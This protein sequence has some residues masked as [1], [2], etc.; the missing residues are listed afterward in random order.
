[1]TTPPTLT[2]EIDVL[3]AA[4]AAEY[5]VEAEIGR[6]G[7]AVVFRAV[8]RDLGRTVALKVLPLAAASDADTVERFLDEARTAAGLE[9]PHVVP[10]HR[11]G[12]AGPLPY[13]AMKLVPGP[14]LGER[15]SRTGALP[16]A[17]VRRILVE[18]ASALGYAHERGIVHRDVKPDNILLEQDGRCMVTD[19]GI[20]KVHRARRLT[21]TGVAVGTPRYMS[22]EQ[23][24]ARPADGRSDLYAL[25]VVGYECL[26]GCVPF[27]ADDPIAVL[28][29]HVQDRPPEPA[30][31]DA[32]ARALWVVLQRLLEKEPAKRYQSAAELLAA[33]GAPAHPPSSTGYAASAPTVR[34]PIPRRLREARGAVASAFNRAPR[35]RRWAAIGVAVALLTGAGVGV[36]HVAGARQRASSR[37]PAPGTKQLVLAPV[38][39]VRPGDRIPVSYEL[40]GFDRTPVTVTISLRA[41]GRGVGRRAATP[42][43]TQV[44]VWPEGASS[45]RAHRLS[46]GTLTPGLYR[47]DVAVR[48]SEGPGP[49]AAMPVRVAW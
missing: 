45:R 15:L 44:G 2:T 37:C 7:M 5:D 19:F 42:L 1:M 35:A 11:V 36:A 21:A 9:H 28:M 25:G 23:A 17:E 4:L 34:T 41:T 46:V 49:T 40:C 3:R 48:S 16:P 30:L 8:E 14:S 26:A 18:T 13:I 10:I 22:P 27:D 6:G 24:R 39:P 47:L 32:E 38:A 20:A 43:T 33:L 29:S 12:R 31:E